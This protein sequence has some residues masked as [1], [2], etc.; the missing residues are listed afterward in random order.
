MSMDVPLLLHVLLLLFLL[1]YLLGFFL[2]A[3]QMV[4]I[5]EKGGEAK[6]PISTFI[7]FGV[8]THNGTCSVL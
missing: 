4:L 6:C 2:Y 1:L 7:N 5:Y 3:E 8:M